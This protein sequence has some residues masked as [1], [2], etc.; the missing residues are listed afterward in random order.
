M[1]KGKWVH[2][3][4]MDVFIE[5]LEAPVKGPDYIKLKILWWNRGQCGIPYC[6]GVCDVIKINNKDLPKWKPYQWPISL[7]E[8]G[9]LS[10]SGSNISWT[11]Q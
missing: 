3:N 5:I 2:E 8:E 10:N 9:S 11:K 1:T 4:S 6:T 7:G